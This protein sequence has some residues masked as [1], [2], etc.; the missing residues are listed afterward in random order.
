ME[1]RRQPLCVHSTH[2]DQEPDGPLNCPVCGNHRRV[3]RGRLQC[4]LCGFAIRASNQG[5]PSATDSDVDDLEDEALFLAS[6]APC[7]LC[8]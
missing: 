8:S 7:V 2:E 5:Q 4:I 1:H 3:V 6:G